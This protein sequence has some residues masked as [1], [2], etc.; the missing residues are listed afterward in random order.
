MRVYT[1][2][3]ALAEQRAAL[4]EITYCR[5][6]GT[7]WSIPFFWQLCFLTTLAISNLWGHVCV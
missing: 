6:G 3:R 4:T 2:E 5:V 7:G 1:D